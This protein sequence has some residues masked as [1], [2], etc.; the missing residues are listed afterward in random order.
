MAA[1][2]I[3]TGVFSKQEWQAKQLHIVTQNKAAQQRKS[4]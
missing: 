4:D 2:C 1:L 3:E